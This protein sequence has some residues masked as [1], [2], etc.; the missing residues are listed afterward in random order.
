MPSLFIKLSGCSVC[1]LL[2]SASG[3]AQAGPRPHFVR[4]SGEAVVSAKPDRAEITIGL[5]TRAPTADAASAQ[6]AAQTTAALNAIKQAL[7]SGG[8]IKTSGY[9]LAP[10]YDYANGKPPH[11]SG[12]EASNSVI[13]TVDQLPL[14]GK[15]IDAATQTG[16][17]NVNGVSFTLKDSSA[18][19]RQALTEAA[20]QARANAEALAKALNVQ[21]VGLLEAEPSES[22]A[23]PRPMFAMAASVA[24]ER[25]ATPIEAGDLEIRAIVTVSLEVR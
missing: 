4:A 23:G 16:A 19:R 24:K 8:Q 3:F 9:S 21:V 6:N 13:V 14:L 1:L 11:L 10:Q 2:A 22:P 12:Y 17:T 7:G 25:V 15:V 20:A 18:V 5:S